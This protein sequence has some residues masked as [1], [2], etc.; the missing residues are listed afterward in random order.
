ME[1]RAKF[2]ELLSHCIPPTV[3]LKVGSDILLARWYLTPLPVQTV[4]DRVVERV[5]E[6]LKADIMH[7]AAIYV[8]VFDPGNQGAKA[9]FSQEVRMRVG[10]KKIYHLEAWVVKVMSLYKVSCH[11]IGPNAPLS[12]FSISYLISICR[13]SI[14]IPLATDDGPFNCISAL[15]D[16]Q[17]ALLQL[18]YPCCIFL[19][20]RGD[21]VQKLARKDSEPQVRHHLNAAHTS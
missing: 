14:E 2:Y 9:D 4:A 10:N 7:W 11:Y 21:E 12:P 5:D 16:I 3:V 13:A 6:S 8:R 19:L 17:C 1:V 20:Y 18:G 15:L